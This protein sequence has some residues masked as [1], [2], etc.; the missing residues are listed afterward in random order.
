MLMPFLGLPD[1]ISPP[2]PSHCPILLLSASQFRIIS[3]IS[4]LKSHSFII[5]LTKLCSLFSPQGKHDNFQCGR[6]LKHFL[7][8]ISFCNKKMGN[9][10][11]KVLMGVMHPTT[12]MLNSI[13]LLRLQV[14][15]ASKMPTDYG[16]PRN[17][18]R[19]KENQTK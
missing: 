11:P 10:V 8:P 6:G 2:Y 17:K 19:S 9:K 7:R 1:T 15:V 13:P 18:T 16:E 3:H 5:Y 12:A 4:F 14:L